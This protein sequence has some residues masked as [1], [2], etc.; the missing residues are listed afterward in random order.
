MKNN[1]IISI[2][3]IIFMNTACSNEEAYDKSSLGDELNSENSKAVTFSGAEMDGVSVLIFG[4]NNS[5]FKYIHAIS[6]GWSAEGKV[7]TLLEIG[8][9]KFLFLK[10]TAENTTFQPDPLNTSS[11]FE[12]IKIKAKEDPQNS[13]YLLPVDE[14]WLPETEAMASKEYLINNPTTIHNK[15]TRAVSQVQLNIRRGYKNGSTIVPYPFPDG[16]NIMENIKEIKMD[17]T[18]VG[19]AITIAGGEGSSKTKYSALSATEITEDGYAIFGGPLVFPNGSGVNSPVKITIVPK[20]DSPFPVM[21]ADVEG[22]LERNKKLEITLWLTSTYK[23]INVTV[24]TEPIS[25]SED[26]DSGIWE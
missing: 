13:G 2:L 22:L 17:I 20:D 3:L 10:Y 8:K 15:L 12:D 25:K 7:S 6:T 14:I 19:Q 21:T 5:E 9:Y 4:H 24:K 16:K 1:I 18:G 11:G 23:F 26:G